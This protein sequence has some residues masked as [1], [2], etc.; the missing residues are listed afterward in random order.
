VDLLQG[1]W[2]LFFVMTALM[3][4]PALLLLRLLSKQAAYKQV[5]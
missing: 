2:A 5:V 3:I 1:N 4:I